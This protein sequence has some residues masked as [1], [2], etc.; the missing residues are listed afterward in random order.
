MR[1]VSQRIVRAEQRNQ[2]RP[3]SCM[4]PV[5]VMV[6]AASGRGEAAGDGPAVDAAPALHGVEPGPAAAGGLRR[7]QELLPDRIDVMG[8]NHQRTL[9]NRF[10]IVRLSATLSEPDVALTTSEL[11]RDCIVA[12]GQS[13][14]VTARA[15]DLLSSLS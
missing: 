13:D 14:D 8:A 6:L 11:V 4:A 7:F 9:R 3:S 10:H 1:L 12:L 2:G 5:I 15:I